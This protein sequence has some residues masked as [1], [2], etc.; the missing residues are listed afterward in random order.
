ML[1][2]PHLTLLSRRP[3]PNF[4]RINIISHNITSHNNFIIYHHHHHHWPLPTYLPT[5]SSIYLPAK[6]PSTTHHFP[7]KPKRYVPSLV[8][9]VRDEANKAC[10]KC[11]R[12]SREWQRAPLPAPSSSRTVIRLLTLRGRKENQLQRAEEDQTP[13]KPLLLQKV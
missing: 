5:P 13:A 3:N 2:L 1:L 9:A 12:Q 10:I 7:S 11:F 8:P 6:S 4:T